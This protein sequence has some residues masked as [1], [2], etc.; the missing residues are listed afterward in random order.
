[1]IA[2]AGTVGL[3]MLVVLLTKISGS[4]KRLPAGVLLAIALLEVAVIFY[5]MST[6]EPPPLL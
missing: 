4:K 6:L 2:L 1:M 3:I 5:Y